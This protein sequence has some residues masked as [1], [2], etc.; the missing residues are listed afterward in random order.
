MRESPSL[1]IMSDLRKLK[2]RVDYHDKYFPNFKQNRSFFENKKSINLTK[3]NLKKYDVVVIS[4]NHSY[5]N[6]NHIYKYSKKILDPRN[7]YNFRSNK[8]IPC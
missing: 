1:K 8:I 7:V 3:D 5:L 6:T 2:F 4:A